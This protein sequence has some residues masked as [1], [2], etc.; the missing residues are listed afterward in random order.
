MITKEQAMTHRGEFWHMYMKNADG[1]PTRCRANGKCMTWKSKPEAWKLPVKYGL[2]DYFYLT[3][4]SAYEWCLPANWPV[5][6]QIFNG[7]KS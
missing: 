2:K 7:V 1:T 4:G 6:H 3:P 5:E